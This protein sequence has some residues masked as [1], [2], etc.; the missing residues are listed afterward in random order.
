MTID[1]MRYVLKIAECGG[2]T[3]AAQE[4]YI[5]Q[6][7][8]SQRL[9]KVEKELGIRLFERNRFG[10]AAPTEAGQRF[11]AE[12]KHILSHWDRLQ[13]ELQEMKGKRRFTLGIP[14]RTGFELVSGLMDAL[15]AVDPNIVLSLV[16]CA[17]YQMEEML[18][19][20][21]LDYALIRM[22]NQSMHLQ[23][24]LLVKY[25]PAVHLREGSPLWDKIYYHPD[26]PFAY[27]R[28]E[29]LEHE[30]LVAAPSSL[31]HRTRKWLDALFAQIPG[32]LPKV[33][34]T[35]PNINMYDYYAKSGTASYILATREIPSGAC[36]MEPDQALPY[37]TYFVQSRRADSKTADILF[38]IL[39]RQINHG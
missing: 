15:A 14:I 3:K 29:E 11:C 12:C 22:P 5:S 23:K 13:Q 34:H 6:P 31:E 28:L 24:R 32:L 39:D 33:V 8:L 10:E 20:G 35:V 18:D 4:L 25:L 37:E 38:R 19:K 16:D 27:I 21:E 30:P 2:F 9:Q 36:R 7:T 17:N 1:D 26:E